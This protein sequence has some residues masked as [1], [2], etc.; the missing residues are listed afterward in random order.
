MTNPKQ[1]HAHPGSLFSYKLP[2]NIKSHDTG[3][4]QLKV[5]FKECLLNKCFYSLHEFL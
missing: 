1:I 3:T 5:A 4:I 2:D